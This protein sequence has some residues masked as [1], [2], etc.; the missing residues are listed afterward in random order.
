MT[1]AMRPR[2]I[3]AIGF[4]A[5]LAYSYPGYMSTDSVQQLI[6]A[7]NGLRS[8][9]HPPLMAFE[10]GFLDAIVAGPLLMLCLQGVLALAGANALLRRA[11]SPQRAAVV[12]C[13]LLLF[14]PILTT[15]GVIWKD[16]QMAGYLLVGT[17]AIVDD[18]RWIRLTGLAAMVAACAMRHNGF[19]A[20]VPLIGLLFVWRMGLPWWKRYAISGATALTVVVLAFA[21]TR[22]LAV[23]HVPISPAMGDIAGVLAYTHDRSDDD[24]RAVLAGTPLHVTRDI[25]TRARRLYSPRNSYALAHG[26]DR[27]FDP[28]T[29]DAQHA[30]LNRAWE[31]L[32]TSDWG[33][34]FRS[35]LATFRELLGLS[36]QPLW[37]PVWNDFLETKNQATW[38]QHLALKSPLQVVLGRWFNVLAYETPLFEPYV[39]A[40]IALVLLACF[41]RE[42][43]TIALLASGLLYELGYFPAT[44]T[45]DV[46][47]SHWMIVCTCLAGVLVFVQR[48][49]RRT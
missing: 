39:Y 40:L 1:S 5:F 41:A 48:Y 14:P 28:P 33:A 24:L 16:A 49:R 44:S 17:A 37:S 45:P 13:A 21:T 47:Y 25:Q 20:A 42:R 22:V 15:F 31:D 23:K 30:A 36:D 18:R 10:W 32:V 3:L 38:V 46:R 29:T 6:E 8:D 35:R 11:L 12:A 9:V 7:R 19:A 26:D 27:L 43:L 4:I 34:Y 2:T